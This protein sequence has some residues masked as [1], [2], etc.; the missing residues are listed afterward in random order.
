MSLTGTAPTSVDAKLLKDIQGLAEDG[1]DDLPP[2]LLALS[3]QV[4][5][6]Y[7][8]PWGQ[9]LRLIL[10]PGVHVRPS[11]VRY[12]L[13]E[14]GA[15]ALRADTACPPDSRAILEHLRKRVM[16]VSLATLKRKH[17]KSVHQS[18]AFLQR[19]HW[20]EE[21]PTPTMRTAKRRAS[22]VTPLLSDGMGSPSLETAW[23]EPNERWKTL[24]R[25][26]FETHREARMVLECSL[27]DR[28][29]LLDW[30]IGL[31]KKAGR[32]VLVLVGEVEK[33]QWTAAH[34]RERGHEAIAELHAGLSEK[35]KAEY[36]SAIHRGTVSLVIGTRSAVFAPL[37]SIGLIWVD[38][39]ESA[40]LKEPQEPRYHA[41]AVAWMRA[42]E[43]RALLTLASDH[44]SLESREEARAADAIL[45][46]GDSNP[47]RPTVE[48]VDLRREGPESML[49]APLREAVRLTLASGGGVV[50]FLNRKGYAGALACRDCGEVPR[51]NSCSVALVFH[52]KI[53]RLVCHYCG[54]DVA[55]PETCPACL[56]PQLRPLGGGT[57]KLEEEARRFFPEA[58]IGRIDRD[59]LRTPS[60]VRS[61]WQRFEA[62]DW[63]IVIGTQLLF[64]RP[65]SS[66][67]GLVGAIHADAGLIVPDF[68]SA[69]RT[70]HS[71]LNAVAMARPAARG[72]RV[73]LQALLPGHHAIQAVVTNNPD[74]FLVSEK[75]FRDALRYPPAVDLVVL[76]VAGR[77]EHA[78]ASAAQ[79]WAA[80]L[81]RLL[82]TGQGGAPASE[83]VAVVGPAPAPLRRL[84]GRY[85]WQMLLKVN[86]L[87]EVLDSLR[88]SLQ[89]M[90]EIHG[91][92]GIR[93]DV[94]VDP[95]DLA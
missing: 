35:A 40:S 50:L 86:R 51:C 27:A 79:Q 57:E 53:G 47:T 31:V 70:Y 89:E 36:W 68:R 38:G 18:V 25:E 5:E 30:A 66:P 73:V 21:T 22:R 37:R 19:R 72:G 56:A 39:E 33:A 7:V 26:A 58:R 49:S 61:A 45:S 32:T 8:A 24:L 93:F 59:V 44:V 2:D 81:T 20:I 15:A 74:L 41:R 16:G 82:A 52:R 55:A 4:A 83:G 88:R 54:Y 71:L 6:R 84:R 94:D 10:P 62:G 92:A 14:R 67:V 64:Q 75:H 77:Q 69:E 17:G 65:L 3:R 13:S 12:R 91:K 90:E 1:G 23:P 48:V 63:D 60:Q 9:C 80:R 34:L 95:V 76:H 78:V 87:R 11:P 42:S 43:H 28:L 85:R 46:R 29:A